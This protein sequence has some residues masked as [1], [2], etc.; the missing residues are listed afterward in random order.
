M[1]LTTDLVSYYKLDGDSN[2]SVGSNDGTDTSVSYVA[3]KIG[4]AA[5]LAGTSKILIPSQSAFNLQSSFTILAW[6]YQTSRGKSGCYEEGI[7]C[8]DNETTGNRC[9]NFVISGP[10][11]SGNVGKL[12]FIYNAV[13]NISLYST[14]T[15]PLDEWTLVGIVSTNGTYTFYKNGTSIGNGNTNITPAYQ[16]TASL[17][18]GKEINNQYVESM[19]GKIDEVGIWSRALTSDEISE[20][21]NSGDGITYPFGKDSSNTIFL[22]NNF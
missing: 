7:V 12:R 19:I 22:S 8:K 10:A 20:I 1:A 14:S 21:Y 4:D 17:F 9:F 11:D 15:I 2:D 5:Q 6:V 3:G 18:I 16:G 13:D